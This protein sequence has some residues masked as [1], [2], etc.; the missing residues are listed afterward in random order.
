[1]RY[2]KPDLSQVGCWSRGKGNGHSGEIPGADQQRP[3]PGLTLDKL[4]QSA[5]S[6]RKNSF[7][8]SERANHLGSVLPGGRKSEVVEGALTSLVQVEAALDSLNVDELSLRKMSGHLID[9]VAAR[10]IHGSAGKLDDVRST[11]RQ[12]ANQSG[13]KILRHIYYYCQN[14]VQLDSRRRHEFENTSSQ[15]VTASAI[16]L[17]V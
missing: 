13:H 11:G 16:G 9:S 8:V 5:K 7:D 2:L 14:C 12:G 1:M 6:H 4:S 15:D 17:V 3:W 10:R